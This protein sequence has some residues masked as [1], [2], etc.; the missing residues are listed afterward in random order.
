MA[1]KI[2]SEFATFLTQLDS[3]SEKAVHLGEELERSK[4]ELQRYEGVKD[5]LESH[6]IASEAEK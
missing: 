6:A 5:A 2:R 3:L 4:Q 1:Q